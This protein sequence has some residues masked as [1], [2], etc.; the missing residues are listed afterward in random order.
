VN[1]QGN[2][3]IIAAII[4]SSMALVLVA[5]CTQAH[6]EQIT[7]TASPPPLNLS[8]NARA[9]CNDLNYSYEVRTNPGGSEYGVCILP[10]GTVC[11]SWDFYRGNCPA[12]SSSGE[13]SSDPWG[14]FCLAMNNTYTIRENPEGG[15]DHVCIFPDGGECDARAYYLGTCSE[16]TAKMP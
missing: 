10:G 6:E 7:P 12:A 9:Y 11:D 13:A 2:Y 4:I 15:V 5:G 1:G 8:A 16:P 3:L 14:D